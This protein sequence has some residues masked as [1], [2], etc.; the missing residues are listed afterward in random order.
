MPHHAL[1]RLPFS[2]H[3]SGAICAGDVAAVL[4]ASR[5]YSMSGQYTLHAARSTSSQSAATDRV[6]AITLLAL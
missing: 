6:G 4:S 1:L 3:F 5:N 2:I